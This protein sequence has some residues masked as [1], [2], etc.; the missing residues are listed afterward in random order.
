MVVFSVQKSIGEQ[1]GTLE[2]S[3]T[4]VARAHRVG[5]KK[6]HGAHRPGTRLR[7]CGCSTKTTGKSWNTISRIDYPGTDPLR[8]IAVIPREICRCALV[9]VYSLSSGDGHTPFNILRFAAIASISKLQDSSQVT[10]IWLI[11]L[12][13]IS[14]SRPLRS[15]QVSASQTDWTSRI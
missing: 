1:H 14:Y 9:G 5:D 13:S 8:R 12:K 7:R 6:R 11:Y 3:T 15:S 10:W 4:I 2:C